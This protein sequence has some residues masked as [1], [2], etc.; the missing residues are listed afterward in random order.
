M[1]IDIERIAREAGFKHPDAVGNC[2][3]FD[4]FDMRK[5][6]ALVLEEAAKVCRELENGFARPYEYSD[7]LAVVLER[8][9]ASLTAK[10]GQ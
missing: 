2:E 1:T 6:A 7:D 5:F 3:D 4:Y 8:I 10:D 9:A